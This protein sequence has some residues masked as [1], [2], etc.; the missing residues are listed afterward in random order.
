MCSMDIRSA[1]REMACLVWCPCMYAMLHVLRVHIQS[2]LFAVSHS[3]ACWVP[4]QQTMLQY[5]P[6]WHFFLNWTIQNTNL[7]QT[8]CICNWY[9][10]WVKKK[11]LKNKTKKKVIN[12]MSA[13]RPV[14]LN[15]IA[16]LNQTLC[17][18]PCLLSFKSS[19]CVCNQS[20]PDCAELGCVFKGLPGFSCSYLKLLQQLGVT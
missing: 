1:C 19:L 8:I 13:R 10:L 3:A 17:S 7:P 20:S 4:T 12:S 6:G 11:L 16:L 14:C 2:L 15:T 5:K 9:L 18:F